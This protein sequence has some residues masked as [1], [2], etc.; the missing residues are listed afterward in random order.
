M[1]ALIVGGGIAGLASA[2]AMERFAPRAFS[3]LNLWER[4]SQ[5]EEVGA[6]VQLGPNATRLLQQWGLGHALEAVAFVPQKLAIYATSH[7]RLTAERPLGALTLAQYG[8]PSYTLH[9]ADLH[10]LLLQAVR[11][12][13]RVQL[14]NERAVEGMKVSTPTG[15]WTVKALAGST[16]CQ[17]EFDCVVGCDGGFSQVRAQVM[18]DGPPL[19]TGQVA[20]RALLPIDSV[21]NQALRQSVTVWMGPK[22]HVVAYPVRAGSLYNLVVIVQDDPGSTRQGWDLRPLVQGLPLP[23][24]VHNRDLAGLL[25]A[26]E[27]WRYWV[28]CDRAPLADARA[29]VPEPS[30]ALLGDAAHPMLPFLAQGAAMAIEDAH[31]LAQ[32]LGAAG[33]GGWQQRLS[34]FGKARWQRNSRVQAGARRNAHIFHL[35][36]PVAWA[37]DAAL[38]V[39][40]PR[41]LDMPWLYGGP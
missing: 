41:L 10:Q 17:Q 5:F 7:N 27:Q 30:V 29:M 26:V 19:P 39:A 1:D 31:T 28:L 33:Q 15:R 12:Q 32:S 3:Q 14:H 18:G 20:Y 8:A 35:K 36:G 23:E 38:N 16:P 34:T 25:E 22:M 21:K 2:F 13:G 6:G 24:K 40:A 11:S 4:A 9:R 37:R